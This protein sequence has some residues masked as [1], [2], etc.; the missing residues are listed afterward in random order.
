MGILMTFFPAF[1]ARVEKG[2]TLLTLDGVL[3]KR[4]FLASKLVTAK[5][6]FAAVLIVVINISVFTISTLPGAVSPAVAS[7]FSLL[8]K[9]QISNFK[10]S[11]S[12]DLSDQ[13][14]WVERR[15]QNFT[16]R[17]SVTSPLVQKNLG[18]QFTLFSKL[19][20]RDA[21]DASADN[22]EPYQTPID[23]SSVI[24]VKHLRTLQTGKNQ[25][26]VTASFPISFLSSGADKLLPT[27]YLGCSQ[28]GC[29]GVYP[30]QVSLIEIPSDIQ[31]STFTTHVVY[32]A[33]E[34]SNL[35]L[36]IGLVI[37][38]GQENLIGSSGG[39]ETSKKYLD[40]IKSLVSLLTAYKRVPLT[41]DLSPQLLFAL[42]AD[43]TLQTK[44]ILP[45]IR[46]LIKIKFKLNTLQVLG[47]P[48]ANVSATQLVNSNLTPQLGLQLNSGFL[49][50][51]HIL[52]IK[53]RSSPYLSSTDVSPK[54]LKALGG[55][56]I[57][58]FILPEDNFSLAYTSTI[59]APVR[60]VKS[61][62]SSDN[63][64]SSYKHNP[65]A[66]LID[67]GISNKFS[68]DQSD[69]RLEASTI[70][71][72]LAQVYFDAPDAIENRSIVIYP[73][74]W[75]GKYLL[76][77]L[78]AGLQSSNIL[79][80]RT[81]NQIFSTVKV[82]ANNTPNTAALSG[83]VPYLNHQRKGSRQKGH[84]K[85]PVSEQISL[86]KGYGFLSDLKSILGTDTY[87]ASS[88]ENSVLASI[89]E[90]ESYN[91]SNTA[92]NKYFLA[93]YRA[94]QR[95]TPSLS[96]SGN[97]SVTLTS[98]KGKI[99]V[100]INSDYKVP[101]NIILK[102]ASS[103]VLVT[104]DAKNILVDHLKPTYFD[105]STRTSGRFILKVQILS[106]KG[107]LLL[108][109]KNYTVTSTAISL[110][111]IILTAFAVLILLIWWLRSFLKSRRQ[112]LLL[113]K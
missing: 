27:L 40:A 52:N 19:T 45:G 88:T 82:G 54:A 36:N 34:G 102:I 69:P 93:G 105:I 15:G 29:D 33:F 101:L 37:P 14:E 97:N 96:L 44:G 59:T 4:R 43:R 100:T 20:S 8:T 35:P 41:L 63:T 91:I 56:G 28:T 103:E 75:G 23:V 46:H 62:A 76:K 32:T 2:L 83:Y 16:I 70:L 25:F 68:D 111:A 6:I 113:R 3:N 74:T 87:F 90:G 80:A 73:D 72:E 55:I 81:A 65:E 51:K 39:I 48:F 12:F 110:E 31:L 85:T 49:T 98:L 17:L 26:L 94:I 99:P 61:S 77:P 67:S 21:Y 106:P 92:R 86:N 10:S 109:S 7:T 18:V 71:G 42:N 24:P 78:L 104:G 57:K 53:T 5:S 60:I 108:L 64:T 89:L 66:L 11:T 9:S 38:M 84:L 58:R 95:I 79:K 1:R 30:L 13:T 112:K 107:H 47:Q 50:E 22:Q